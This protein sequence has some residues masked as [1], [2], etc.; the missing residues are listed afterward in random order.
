MHPNPVDAP[1]QSRAL[2]QGHFWL[3]FDRHLRDGVLTIGAIHQTRLGGKT[4][5]RVQ[6]RDAQRIAQFE[7][8]I[9]TLID[10]LYAER[11]DVALD[12][13][14]RGKDHTLPQRS[15]CAWPI[16]THGAWERTPRGPLYVVTQWFWQDQDDQHHHDGWDPHTTL[17]APVDARAA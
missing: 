7:N 3:T 11:L 10:D 13:K 2:T 5:M 12:R 6:I 8:G 1:Y 17:T 15:D 16:D 14:A 9:G 4:T